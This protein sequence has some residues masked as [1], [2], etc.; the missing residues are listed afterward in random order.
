M[1]EKGW[2]RFTLIELLV[3]IAIIAILAAML[4]PALARAKS[5]AKRVVC[6]NQ[7]KQLLIGGYDYAAS[8]N[9]NLPPGQR[10]DGF[11]HCVWAATETYEALGGFESGTYATGDQPDTIWVCPNIGPAPFFYAAGTGWVVSYNY[12]GNHPL[13]STVGTAWESAERLSDPGDSVL[14][15]DLNTYSPGQWST[16]NHYYPSGQFFPSTIG[17]GVSPAAM[18]SE[19]GN[20]GYLDGS[21][22]WKRNT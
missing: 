15:N 13:A 8:N 4:L 19:G 16:V 22:R 14:L 6:A 11:E 12:L 2:F 10:D 18:G 1:R 17:G 21:V 5:Q 9:R 3:V 7:Q 20:L